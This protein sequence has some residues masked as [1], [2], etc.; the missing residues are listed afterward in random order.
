MI[1]D[2]VAE[3]IVGV[4]RDGAL[5]LALLL[6]TGGVFAE[7]LDDT[8]TLLLPSRRAEIEDALLSLRGHV[9]LSGFRGRPTGDF[10]ALVETIMAVCTFAEAKADTLIELD[11]NP[12]IVRPDGLG[13]VAVD[14]MMTMGEDD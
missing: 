6:G 1:G 3:F 12:V 10:D 11:L 8:A 7:L 13:A 2:G 9:L 5:G 14:A 4:K